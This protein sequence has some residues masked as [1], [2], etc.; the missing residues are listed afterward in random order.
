[1]TTIP[2]V[3]IDVDGVFANF[4]RG[5][6]ETLNGIRP[7]RPS[8]SG[9][10]Y[11]PTVWNYPTHELGCTPAELDAIAKHVAESG[12]WWAK[13]HHYEG[14]I[15]CLTE[16]NGMMQRQEIDGTF[17]TSRKGSA[18]NVRFQTMQWLSARGVTQPQVLVVEGKT[19]AAQ[20]LEADAIVDDRPSNLGVLTFEHLA[21]FDRPW[22]QEVALPRLH[23]YGALIGW[24]ASLPRRPFHAT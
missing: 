6:V 4:N 23:G 11:E 24:L 14:A 19:Q 13:L 17:V 7:D 2:R 18:A 20:V 1:M 5:F 21:L 15:E 12:S 22:N 9:K 8:I 3:V 10:D 16:I